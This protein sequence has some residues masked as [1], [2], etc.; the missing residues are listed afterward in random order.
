MP[1]NVHRPNQISLLIMS[2]NIILGLPN[3][4]KLFTKSLSVE[5]T[6]TNS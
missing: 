5:K 1:K 3:L 2:I 6:T 4:S